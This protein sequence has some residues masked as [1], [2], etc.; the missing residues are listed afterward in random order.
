V[1][2][3]GFTFQ[4]PSFALRA[5]SM[6]LRRRAG[7]ATARPDRRR[8]AARRGGAG[9]LNGPSGTV[10]IR[11]IGSLAQV[12]Y[13][14]CCGAI[15]RRADRHSS[16]TQSKTRPLRAEGKPNRPLTAFN[17]TTEVVQEKR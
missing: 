1:L 13:N 12:G 5:P 17:M 11:P 14:W 2:C 15:A 9:I 4:Q 6:E 3:A 16:G 7:V 8:I 10:S